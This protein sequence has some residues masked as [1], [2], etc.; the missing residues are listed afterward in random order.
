MTYKILK[1]DSI[2]L[3][4]R[5]LKSKYSVYLPSTQS[6]STC[7]TADEPAFKIASGNTR[8]SAKEMTFPQIEL[9]LSY[10]FKKDLED[11]F[12]PTSIDIKTDLE[13]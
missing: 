10:E 2:D 11:P 12:K 3:L 7:L 4:L 1:K 8:L 13:Y 6:G 9:L 5:E